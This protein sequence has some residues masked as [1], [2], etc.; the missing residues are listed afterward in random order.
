MDKRVFIVR[1]GSAVI[2]SREKRKEQ[3]IKA[4]GYMR[5]LEERPKRFYI[6]Q[7]RGVQL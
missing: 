7:N 5:A 1:K 4:E 3:Q 2:P 6:N